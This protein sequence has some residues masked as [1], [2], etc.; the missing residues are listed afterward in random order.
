M[1]RI[2]AILITLPMVLH[3][4]A[5]TTDQQAVDVVSGTV[6]DERTGRPIAQATVSVDGTSIAV[7]TNDDGYFTLKKA[8]TAKG[9]TVSYVGYQSKHLK[10]P[11]SRITLVPTAIPLNEVVV[12]TEDPH[13]LVSIAIRKIPNNYSRQPELFQGFYRETAMKRQH[14]IY[15]AEAVVDMYKTSYTH[16]D[17]RDR[18]AI[19]K[20]RRLLSAKQGDTLTVKVMGGP[21][22][23]IQ[24]DVVKNPDLLLSVEELNNYNFAMQPTTTIDNRLQYVVD[25]SPRWPMPWPLYFGRLYID[26]ET[27]AFTR[28]ELQLDVSDREKATNYMLVRRPPG[29]RFRPRELSTLI[30]YRYEQGVTRISYIRNIFRFNCDWRR[31]LF[32]TSFTACCEMVFTDHQPATNGRPIS[33][34]DSFDSRDNFYDKVSYFLDPLFW[35]DYNIIEPSTSLDQA[36][37]KLLK[38]KLRN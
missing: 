5:Q 24:L 29:V 25:I 30:D 26:R 21:V 4:C 8:S 14:Y 27:L 11:V 17:S 34:R 9:I 15:V 19:R 12:W 2:I 18:V 28:V 6:V 31:K 37:D 32:A 36:I 10:A 38:K 1:N 16:N 33:G 3:L 35:E 23:P 7:V 13:Q 20:G 22:L